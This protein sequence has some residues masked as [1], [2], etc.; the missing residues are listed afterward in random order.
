MLTD[1]AALKEV[2]FGAGV[3]DAI[4]EDSIHVCLS[5]ISVSLSQRLTEEHYAHRRH[6]VGAPVF[7][8]PPIAEEGR[9][10]TVVGGGTDQVEKMR[11]LL[12]TF[13]RGTTVVGDQ[14]W[15][16]H[17]MKLGGNFMISAI[18]AS[19]SE[20]MIY[21]EAMQIEPAMFAETVNNALFRSPLYEAYGKL[22]LHPPETPGSTVSILDKDTR[23]FREAA[24]VGDVRTPLADL[25]YAHWQKPSKQA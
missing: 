7:G 21:A 6:F 4:P 1:D 14:P 20:G 8:R 15:S 13:S 25:A 12:D 18:L 24:K 17:A 9:L 10:W 23:L 22:M 16:A 2:L 11:P 19:L 5:T 3:L